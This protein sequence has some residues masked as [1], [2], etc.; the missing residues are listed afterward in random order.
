MNHVKS[1]DGIGLIELMIAMAAGFVVL[2]TMIQALTYFQ[3]RL[4]TQQDTMAR[5]QDQRIGIQVMQEELRL[6]GPGASGSAPA[7][8]SANRQ[9]IAFFANLSG[10]VTTLA[11]A[12]NSTQ[13]ELHVLDGAGW[14]RGKRILVCAKER[15]AESRLAQEGQRMVL[16][17]SSAL[18]ESFPTGSEVFIS[19]HVRYYLAK[20]QNGTVSLMR[21]VDGGANAIIG[22]IAAFSLSYVDRKGQ[23]TTD[24]SAVVRVRAELVVGQDRHP[25][26]SEV[27]LR[28][29]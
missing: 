21:Q 2:M 6:A 20:N 8:L 25:I 18:G 10:E 19:N 3:K 23:I 29:R 26:I 24:P 27:A 15:C 12:V 17:L 22:E 28:S 9:E 5:H 4:V 14:P 16:S 1:C 7:L 13:Q 11:G